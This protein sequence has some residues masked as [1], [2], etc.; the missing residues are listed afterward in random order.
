MK[1]LF[2]FLLLLAVLPAGAQETVSKTYHPNGKLSEITHQGSFNGCGVPVGTDS[3]FSPA[4]K[5]LRTKS[6]THFLSGSGCHSIITVTEERTYFSNGRSKTVSREQIPYEGEA[7]K[8]GVWK[9][10]DKEGRIM[11]KQEWSDCISL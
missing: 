8:C 2:S 6:Y 10:F 7:Q 9:W 4:G 1:I 5:L 3:L 11:R